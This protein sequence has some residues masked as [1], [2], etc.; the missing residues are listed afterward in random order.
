MKFSDYLK[1][2]SK[3]SGEYGVRWREFDKNDKLKTKEK[4]FKTEKA[5]DK[6]IDKIE[7]SDNFYEIVAT[8]IPG[9]YG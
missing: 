3:G 8:T 5:R 7:N 6:F 9:F 4:F 2:G 1:E